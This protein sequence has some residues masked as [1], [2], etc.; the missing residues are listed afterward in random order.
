MAD[1][2]PRIEINGI[3]FD[4]DGTL[5]DFHATWMPAYR[6]AA[7]ALADG[8]NELARWML[9]AA[10][11]D[12]AAGTVAPGSL[13][14]SGTIKEIAEA[15]RP[16]L[17]PQRI[18]DLTGH[19]VDVFARETER[20]ST[21]VTN[22]APLFQRLK[23]RGLALGVVTNDG[24]GGARRALAAM[25]IASRLDFVAGFDSGH[26]EKPGP[27][28][29]LAFA[30]AV[31]LR[32]EN[33]AVVGDELRD[34]EMG[35]RAGAGLLVAVLTGTGVRTELTA[36]SDHVLD[37]VEMIETVLDD[38]PASQPSETASFNGS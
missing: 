19:L 30:G 3:L 17:R 16:F 13:L 4:K 32:P 2:R 34:L 7:A 24:E 37:N 33:V 14:A 21:S 38:P 20:H 11:C 29:V 31:G 26:G 22:L 15:W 10:G 5:L 6:N 9:S 23:A 28:M 35:R 25:D 1:R 8:D 36:M 27:G 12:D 18:D